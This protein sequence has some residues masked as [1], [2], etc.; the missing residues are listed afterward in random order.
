MKR[1]R[2]KYEVKVGDEWVKVT[3]GNPVRMGFLEYEIRRK[4]GTT[5]GLAAP[6]TWRRVGST[7]VPRVT[8]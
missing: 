8:R 3:I 1:T 2:T 5:N 4:E 7:D 6:N